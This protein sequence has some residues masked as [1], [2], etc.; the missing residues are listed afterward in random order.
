M[1]PLSPEVYVPLVASLAAA[2]AGWVVRVER[3]VA[4]ID[5]VHSDVKEVK[6]SVDAIMW[7]LVKR[8]AERDYPSTK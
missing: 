1:L 5:E 8:Q 7:H 4:K 2:I 6:S 3:K